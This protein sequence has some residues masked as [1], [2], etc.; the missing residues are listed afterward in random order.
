MHEPHADAN[1]DEQ[2]DELGRRHNLHEA[3]AGIDAA[4]VDGGQ[5]GEKRQK[6]DG[7]PGRRLGGRP[8]DTHRGRKRA[9]DRGDGE[10]RHQPVEDAAHK[11]D[12]GAE[13][14]F[15]VGVEPAGERDAAAGRREA[16]DDERHEHGADE[17]DERSG[18]AESGGNRGRQDEDT[19]ADG[20]VDDAGREAAHA[21]RTHE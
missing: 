9:R 15:D 18:W 14:D 4:H 8:E 12:R 5:Q 1:Q 11:P 2:R 10:Q 13:C 16:Q 6:H 17:V 20:G 3:R 7:A 19:G 21:D